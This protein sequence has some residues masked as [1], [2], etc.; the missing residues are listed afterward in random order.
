MTS[1]QRRTLVHSRYVPTALMG[2]PNILNNIEGLVTNMEMAF[3]LQ[4]CRL[5]RQPPRTATATFLVVP[6][7]TVYGCIVTSHL[8]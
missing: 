8:V 1:L 5:H 6:S 4:P 3:W 2:A 7:S